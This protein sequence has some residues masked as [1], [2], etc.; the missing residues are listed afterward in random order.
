MSK[1]KRTLELTREFVRSD[2][3]LRYRDSLFGFLWV[4]LKPFLL[5][6]VLALVFTRLFGAADPQYPEKLLL[7]ILLFSYFS[8][9]TSRGISSLLERAQI[10]GRASFPRIVV[11]A[12][13]I[14]TALLNFLAAAIAFFVLFTLLGRPF[15]V[16]FL[17]FLY[18]FGLVFLLTVFIF[19]IAFFGSV[20]FVRLRDLGLVWEVLLQLL[21]FAT[22]ILYPL[23]F[24][25]ERLQR[26]VLV[27]P[28][29][30]VVLESKAAIFSATVSPGMSVL[31]AALLTV[32]LFLFGYAFFSHAVK[33][34]VEYL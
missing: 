18:V 7:G 4:L 2:F 1:A 17:G 32:L 15:P 24:L 13:P 9:A 12:S 3:S 14:I 27:N 34:I 21:F 16:S 10:L 33:R 28:L 20:L 26:L 23:S 5:F 30:V 31:V 22:P 19:G 11:V 8:E 25:P 6:L 29:A